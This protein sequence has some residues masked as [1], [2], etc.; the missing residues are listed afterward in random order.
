MHYRRVLRTGNAGPAQP[1]GEQT[2]VCKAP[3]CEQ[4]AEARGYCHGHYLRLLRNGD[5][6]ETPLRSRRKR[7]VLK[8]ELQGVERLC[9]VPDCDRPHKAKGDCAAHYKRLLATGDPHP[10]LPIRQSEGLG[11]ISHGYWNV[12][13]PPQ[14]RYLVGGQST[15]G[16]HRLVMAL[17]L[18]R[19]LLP[20]EVVHHRNRDRRDNRIENLELWSIAHPKGGRIEDVL[21]F[22]V[23]ML[24]RYAPE[25]RSWVV[26]RSS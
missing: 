2:I 22:C 23:E 3:E 13:V 5:A 6:D 24:A 8:N 9:S 25:V 18:G 19:P 4:L 10:E 15:V 26:D 12:P 1:R 14:L 20:D 7:D 16:E 11:S 21:R 17:H